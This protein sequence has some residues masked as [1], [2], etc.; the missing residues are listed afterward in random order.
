MPVEHD[1][2]RSGVEKWNPEES[3][4]GESGAVA[5]RRNRELSSRG[6]LAITRPMDQDGSE[7]VLSSV[8][9]LAS[10][11]VGTAVSVD[12]SSVGGNTICDG[13]GSFASEQPA[14]AEKAGTSRATAVNS[15][16]EPRRRGPY[17]CT[18]STPKIVSFY[19][20]APL[21][22]PEAI[23]LWQYAVC[24]ALGLRGRIIVSGH[25]INVTVGGELGPVKRYVT[26]TRSYPA[27]AKLTPTWSTGTGDDFPRL[28]V[29]TRAEVV[30]FGVPD[31]VTVDADGVV[32]TG[33]RLSPRELHELVTER[34]DDVVFLDG[35]NQVE[36]QIGHFAGAVTT[37]A[38]TTRDFVPILDSG[39]LDHLKGRP[40]V[41][42]CTGG[43]RCEVL[44][45]LMRSRGF[46][47]VYQLDGG[48]AAYGAEYGDDGL[49][50]GSMYVF[51]K[52]MSVDFSDHTELVGRCSECGRATNLVANY[53]DELGRELAV[54]CD[55]CLKGLEREHPDTP[56][57]SAV[58]DPR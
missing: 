30:T 7:T 22:D 2:R 50:S 25:G 52:R 41:T 8:G 19:V 40:V 44:S 57:A 15:H 28:S 31:E 37:G 1:V 16:A 29:R 53:P 38:A 6:A 27:F 39:A 12:T 4:G 48:I 34:G 20:F 11:V 32:G 3:W 43:V 24:D 10:E 49:W 17:A 54:I 36:A 18:V 13:F 9:S 33:T 26:T 35:R 45:A 42:Y 51:D 56:F 21:P 23:R 58:S 46:G 47:E 14:R 5:P 55:G